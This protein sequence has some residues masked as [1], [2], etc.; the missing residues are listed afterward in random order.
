[1]CS[2]KWV[3]Q[4]LKHHESHFQLSWIISRPLHLVN[5][6][7]IDL[8]C[9][10]RIACDHTFRT[11]HSNKHSC[12]TWCCRRH[13]VLQSYSTKSFKMA[14]NDLFQVILSKICRICLSIRLKCTLQRSTFPSFC[15]NSPIFPTTPKSSF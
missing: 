8:S 14:K 2:W 9:S 7:I 4:T 12:S 13:P 1:M 3:L 10:C 11:C 5:K 6:F 15:L